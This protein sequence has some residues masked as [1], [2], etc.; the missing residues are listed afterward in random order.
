M[1][2]EEIVARI[3]AGETDL[4]P[5]L[6]ERVEG[7]VK[8]KAN[9]FLYDHSTAYGMD[10]DD[11]CQEGFFAVLDA[12]KSYDPATCSCHFK[13]YLAT[14]ISRRYLNLVYVRPGSDKGPK[15]PLDRS[16]SL[17]LPVDDEDGETI[18]DT[19]TDGIDP[20]GDVLHDLWLTE[21]RETMEAALSSIKAEQAAALRRRWYGV[22]GVSMSQSERKA[23]D[24]GLMAL[25][26][27]SIYQLLKGFRA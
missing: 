21:L 12:V 2:V 15:N 11:L 27:P 6:W 16:V 8:K 26:K 4:L 10:F 19:L 24:R 13:S 5:M 20:A 7:F 3:K 17:D 23:A 18:A 25:R 1:T 9:G 22:S 14:V